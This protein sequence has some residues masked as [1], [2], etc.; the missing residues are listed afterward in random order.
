MLTPFRKPRTV[1]AMTALIASLDRRLD[2][3][4]AI[5]AKGT[6]ARRRSGPDAP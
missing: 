6:L 1:F 3:L 2:R 4:F 5:L